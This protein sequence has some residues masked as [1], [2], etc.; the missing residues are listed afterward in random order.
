MNLIHLNSGIEFNI[1]ESEKALLENLKTLRD[2]REI[3][4]P[5]F[6]ISD[7]DLDEMIGGISYLDEEKVVECGGKMLY[8]QPLKAEGDLCGYDVVFKSTIPSSTTLIHRAPLFLGRQNPVY[9]EST[10]R[11]LEAIFGEKSKASPSYETQSLS[12]LICRN[13]VLGDPN[14]IIKRGSARGHPTYLKLEGNNGTNYLG[15]WSHCNINGT[16]NEV[17]AYWNF[18][19]S[20]EKLLKNRSIFYDPE[21]FSTNGEFKRT[22]IVFGGIPAQAIKNAKIELLE[23]SNKPSNK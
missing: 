4:P 16:E 13:K 10:K 23:S 2:E 9:N 8:S 12:A 20:T 1:E 3:K 11:L 18:E 19:I 17:L 15:G 21:G 6:K 22:F 5:R 14:C 7:M